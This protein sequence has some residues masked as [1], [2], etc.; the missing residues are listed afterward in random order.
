MTKQICGLLV[1]LSLSLN[2]GAQSKF[3]L[4]LWP[5]GPKENNDI[6]EPEKIVDETRLTN[7]SE[8]A[9]TV[10]L[11]NPAKATGAAVIVCPGGGYIREAISHEGSMVADWLNEQGIVAIILKYRLPNGHCNI[12]LADAQRAIRMVKANASAWKIDTSKVGIAGFSAGGHLASTAGTHFDNGNKTATDSVERFSSRP[13]LMILFYPVISMKVDL[14]HPGSRENLLGKNPSDDVVNLYSNEL[15]VK[16]NTPPTMIFLS[17][18][19]K[20]VPPLNSIQF[21]TALRAKNIPASMHIFPVGG[22]GWGMRT[23][24][25][26]YKE[27]RA[28][29]LEWFHDYQFIK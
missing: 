17:D 23:N 22:H 6:T 7:V 14:A 8:A 25:P 19:D 28:L 21:Y 12:P 3:I 29:L 1:I 2:S 18:D 15:Q 10:Q 24:V 11:P 9:I 16:N 4:P 13:N 20:S 5:N 27:W 26:F